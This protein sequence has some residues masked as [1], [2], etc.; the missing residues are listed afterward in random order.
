MRQIE[1]RVGRQNGEHSVKRGDIGGEEKDAGNQTGKRKV[2]EYSVCKS[3]Q[4]A[5]SGLE[6]NFL[7]C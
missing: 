1:R 4:N 2:G 5:P 7:A 6:T 3:T